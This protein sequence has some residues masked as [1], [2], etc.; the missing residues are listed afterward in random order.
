M[1]PLGVVFVCPGVGTAKV[2]EQIDINSQFPKQGLTSEQVLE[3]PAFNDVA[4]Q[5]WLIACGAQGRAKV[6]QYLIENKAQVDKIEFYQR[7]D[8]NPLVNIDQCEYLI[9]TSEHNLHLS[10]QCL[11]EK[12]KNI[13]L[14]L[15]SQRLMDIASQQDWAK[16]IKIENASD[17]GILNAI[18]SIG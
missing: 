15:S 5:R 17:Q 2:L 9:I 3:L 4:G 8:L 1:L 12:V 11:G 6:E 7:R 18:K 13:N 16:I 10:A 14:M